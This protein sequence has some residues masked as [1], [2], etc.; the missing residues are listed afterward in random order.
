MSVSVTVSGHLADAA[1]QLR[2][3]R[4]AETRLRTRLRARVSAYDFL[5]FRCRRIH[6]RPNQR[7]RADLL[8][9]AHNDLVARGDAGDCNE[10]V[11]GGTERHQMLLDLIVSAD[12]ID[13]TCRVDWIQLPS[14]APSAHPAAHRRAGECGHIAQAAA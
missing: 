3:T 11:I 13:D 8:Q 4:F 2:E 7:A 6:D 12:D 5:L 9:V 14:A 1:H 10:V